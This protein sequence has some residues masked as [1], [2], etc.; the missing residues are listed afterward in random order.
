MKNPGKKKRIERRVLN[1]TQTDLLKRLDA[2]IRDKKSSPQYY[3]WRN[4]RH[5]GRKR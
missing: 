3:A 1:S 4:R 5:R 2:F